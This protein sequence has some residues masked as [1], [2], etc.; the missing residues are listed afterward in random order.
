MGS[1]VYRSWFNVLGPNNS[2]GIRLLSTKIGKKTVSGRQ[3]AAELNTTDFS[4]L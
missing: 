2:T 3:K 4:A 1:I